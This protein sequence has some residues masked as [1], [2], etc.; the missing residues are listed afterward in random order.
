M[1]VTRAQMV[2]A[3]QS[4]FARGVRAEDLMET[5]GERMADFVRQLVGPSAHAVVFFGKGHNGGDVLVAA[6]HLASAGWSLELRPCSRDL[7]PLTRRQ[8]DRLPEARPRLR[9]SRIV[10]LDGLLGIGARGEPTDDVAD[11]IREINSLR[12]N[13]G[14]LVVAADLPSGLDADSGAVSACCV[15]ADATVTMGFVK[16]G[17]VADTAA[18]HVGRLAVVALDLEAP[19]GADPSSVLTPDVLRPLLPRRS[20]DTHKGEAGRV[21]I[22]A[23]SEGFTGAARLCSAAAVRAG[24]GLVTLAVPRAIYPILAASAVPEVMVMPWGGTFPEGAWDA[25]AIGPGF[26]RQ[27]DAEVLDL[28]GQVQAPCIVDADALNA[29]AAAGESVWDSSPGP[30]LLT[31]HPGEMERLS[32]RGN[33]TRREW[34]KDFVERH[35]V[36]LLLKGSRTIIGSGG[37]PPAFNSTGHPGMASGGMGDVLTGVCAA[38]AGG[39]LP[40]LSAAKLGAW[41]CGHAAEWAIREGASA[42]SLCASDVL[43]QLGP[44]FARLRGGMVG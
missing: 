6:R 3:E 18:G 5:A 25:V 1:I 29:V 20:F 21:L 4:A 32:P 10:V 8:L 28:L 36:T 11:A 13:E 15:Q 34:M 30:R 7:A 19:A 12:R 38:L 24:A 16:Q 23:G 41:I 14:A 17:L 31:P 26:G 37:Q 44:A 40:L 33:R 2:E 43:H 9:P 42:E 27:R 22:L 35:P 39:G